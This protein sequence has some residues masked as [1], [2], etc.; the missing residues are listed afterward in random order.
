MNLP[1]GE[2]IE[3]ETDAKFELRQLCGSTGTWMEP[4]WIQLGVQKSRFTSSGFR[5]G[6]CV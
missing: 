5:S 6:D 1:F 3:Q 2:N 4:I